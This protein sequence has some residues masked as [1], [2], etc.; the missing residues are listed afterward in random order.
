MEPLLLR[1]S[2]ARRRRLE[3]LTFLEDHILKPQ[4]QEYPHKCTADIIDTVHLV[5]EEL[6]RS[7]TAPRYRFCPEV[8]VDHRDE[9]ID[10]VINSHPYHQVNLS[11]A[12]VDETIQR[13]DSRYREI[14]AQP[15][16]VKSR[17]AWIE[18]P[19]Q[20][21]GVEIEGP[22]DDGWLSIRKITV[23]REIQGL[24]VATRLVE[25]LM[26]TWPEH[27]WTATW[28]RDD[29]AALFAHLREKYPEKGF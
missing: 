18:T 16:V 23:E 15:V 28:L 26:Q 20:R 9:I 22:T 19:A 24:G 7:Q 6:D 27:R 10:R 12:T 17:T 1:I 2:H 14:A 25:A 13:L 3:Y 4:H 5:H 21:T 29:G 11:V 8:V